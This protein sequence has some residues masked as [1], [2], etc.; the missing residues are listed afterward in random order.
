V[1]EER[2]SRT[3][4]AAALALC[5][6]ALPCDRPEPRPPTAGPPSRGAARLLWGLPLDL[7]R[8]DERTLQVLPGIG[9]TRARAILAARPFCKAEE[10]LRVP[11]IGPATLRRLAWRIAA[12]APNTDC[13]D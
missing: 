3:A 8:E 7:N 1:R 12:S 5:L 2:A 6:A 13:G 10:L 9:P 4:L 11:G